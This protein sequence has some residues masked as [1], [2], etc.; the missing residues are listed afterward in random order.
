MLYKMDS[1]GLDSI[2][3]VLCY[4]TKIYRVNKTRF[5]HF[6][7]IDHSIFEKQIQSG[8]FSLDSQVIFL[9]MH[10]YRAG[11]TGNNG[12]VG[13]G[14]ELVLAGHDHCHSAAAGHR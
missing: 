12:T 6:F 10:P 8:Q 14:G 13:A 2:N 11:N 4:F 5:H 1:I 9:K 3:G 7:L